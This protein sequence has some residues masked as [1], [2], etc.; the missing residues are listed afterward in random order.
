MQSIKAYREKSI[1]NE[2]FVLEEAVFFNCTLKNCDLFYSGGEF[3]VVESR[4][5][6]CR[7]HFRGAAKNM[8]ALMMSLGML[9]APLQL[10]AQTVPVAKAN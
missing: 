4:L 5:D 1:S 2:S 8:Q 9:K 10:A 3:Q 7:I 6:N